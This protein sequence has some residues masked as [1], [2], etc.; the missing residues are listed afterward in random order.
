MQLTGIVNN[1]FALFLL[2]LLSV[3]PTSLTLCI[4]KS[5][6]TFMVHEKKNK[7]T[8]AGVLSIFTTYMLLRVNGTKVPS[9][10][11]TF[12]FFFFCLRL[13]AN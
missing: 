2:F 9:F 11:F 10:I 13:V 12:S 5:S 8:T 7:K 6:D 1:N 4:E 3:I